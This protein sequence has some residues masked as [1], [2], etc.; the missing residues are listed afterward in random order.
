[1][2]L[3]V[4]AA[5][6]VMLSAG[7]LFG[8]DI[9]GLVI[10]GDTR[11]PLDGAIVGIPN[12][13]FQM[14]SGPDGRFLLPN[15]PEDAA[16][17]T[18]RF[19]GYSTETV[20]LPVGTGDLVIVLHEVILPAR[21]VIVT[22]ARA[23]ENE[24][25]ITFSTVKAQEIKE[26]YTVKDI[27]V[28]L[29]E[30][31]STTYYSESGSGIGYT[32]LNIRGFDQRRIA[33]MVNGVPQND[34]E[35]HSVYWLDFPDLASNLDDIQV[36]RGAGSMT[37]G[38]P[39]IGGSINLVTT[40]FARE[41]GLYVSAGAGSFDT[42]KYSFAAHS[43]IFD[44]RYA[45]YARLS[46]I[47]SN[48]YR[49]NSWVD[50]GSYFLGAVRFDNNMSTQIN[51]YGG[52]V[53]D[54][55][56]YY[57]IAKGDVTD[58]VLRKYNPIARPEEIEN[59]SQ[60][61][62]EL[63]NEWQAAPGITVNNTVFYIKGTGF[64]DYDGSWAPYS[65]YRI[66]KS[67]GFD[68]A[69]DPDTLYIPNALIHAF[70][71]NNQFGWVP[72]AT[73]D[74]AGGT[75]I[76]GGEL[77]FH[78]SE[79]W[80]TLKWG[81]GIPAGVTPDYRYYSYHGAKTMA[82]LYGHDLYRLTDRFMAMADIQCAYSAYRLYDEQYVGTDF[83]KPYLFL[84]PKFGINYAA[85]EN[86]RAYATISRTSREPELKNLY[87]AAE[88]S[89]PVSWGAVTPQFGLKADGTYDVTS[90]LVTEETMNAAEFGAGY[91]T[92]E[93]SVSLNAYIMEFDNEIVKSGRVD[94]FG[95]PVT[96]NAEKTVHRGIELSAHWH[97]VP[98]I[99]VSGNAAFSRNIFIHHTEFELDAQYAAVPIVL[100][101]KRI[102]GFPDLIA[103]V[104]VT[105]R[106]EPVAVSCAVRHVGKFYTTNREEEQRTVDAFSVAECSASYTV[107]N[108]FS[109]RS[110]ELRCEV[111]NLFDKLYAP[112]G[113][114][115][116]YFPAATR[117][118]F[119]TVGIEL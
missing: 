27:P 18:V 28:L 117:S 54:H 60:P 42:R 95:Q 50:F 101:Q 29:S 81:E 59:F 13:R 75:L 23:R 55:L 91:T 66:T 63:I 22:A 8:R 21:G 104:R 70:V 32:Y 109:L 35:D 118:A 94:R 97:P 77:R 112:N 7:S 119:F 45:V 110:I 51:L 19:L 79:H 76:V 49:D 85:S 71:E 92:E 74:H 56:A 43:G 65:Y 90:P 47:T 1:M 108:V 103:N 82:S 113:E 100:D 84:N 78:R 53:A 111:S 62:Y 4:R 39:A 33:V 38:A 64:F 105:L 116:Q 98:A 30:L 83:T 61:H 10:A 102:S 2:I 36:Q 3:Y 9:R 34:P 31:P 115:D 80:G 17:L 86:L 106:L 96:G 46:T 15:V 114:G 58:R 14:Q 40:N 73:I 20:A 68:V 5:L 16:A 87:N 88:A 26:R 99:D 12:S 67:N 52:P 57:G 24:T 41:K 107:S 48:G 6:I 69:G 25:P 37:I 93:L 11:Q 72:R 89:T 44:D